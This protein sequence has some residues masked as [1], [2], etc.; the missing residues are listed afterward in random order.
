M[1][2]FPELDGNPGSLCMVCIKGNRWRRA[3]HVRSLIQSRYITNPQ[4]R[5]HSESANLRQDQG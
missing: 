2:S 5:E 3:P 1:D 4:T